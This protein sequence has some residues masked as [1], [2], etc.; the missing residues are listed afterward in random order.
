MSKAIKLVLFC[1]LGISF[2]GV[3]AVETSEN[4]FSKVHVCYPHGEHSGADYEGQSGSAD[5]QAGVLETYLNKILKREEMEERE[6][7]GYL[8][9]FP[10]RVDPSFKVEPS[11][12]DA[13]RDN[14]RVRQIHELKKKNG[15]YGY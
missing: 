5:R 13:M 2:N 9:K 6:R 7:L 10:K 3:G 1:L 8:P 11:F 12:L 4:C 14:D 15:V